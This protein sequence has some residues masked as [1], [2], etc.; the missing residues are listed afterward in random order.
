MGTELKPPGW[1][2]KS[3]SHNNLILISTTNSTNS[4]KKVT[5]VL[6]TPWHDED[7][8]TTMMSAEFLDSYIHETTSVEPLFADTTTWSIAPVESNSDF[9]DDR[10]PRLVP[11]DTILS[12][13][14]TTYLHQG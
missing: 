2:D 8:M 12:F 3:D 5:P 4:T 6:I 1:Q 7:Y 10:R 11:I 14:N 9:H 13:A